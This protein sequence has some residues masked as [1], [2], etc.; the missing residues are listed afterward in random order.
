MK[1]ESQGKRLT[2]LLW[3]LSMTPNPERFVPGLT[4]RKIKR[5][6]KQEFLSATARVCILLPHLQQQVRQIS[7]ASDTIKTIFL[8]VCC[9][10]S[11]DR[12]L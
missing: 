3:V 5:V 10:A 12:R 2:S 8:L 4:G 11:S 9:L 1:Q 6:E 7:L